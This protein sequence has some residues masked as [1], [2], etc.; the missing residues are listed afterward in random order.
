MD[1]VDDIAHVIAVKGPGTLLSAQAV[2]NL[3]AREALGGPALNRVFNAELPRLPDARSNLVLD[4]RRGGRH[5]CTD[6]LPD[7]LA[8]IRRGRRLWWHAR[9]WGFSR[10]GSGGRLGR[11]QVCPDLFGSGPR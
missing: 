3:L 7:L 8:E 9:R 10:R 6:L 5:P 1:A 11:M 2:G 4:R